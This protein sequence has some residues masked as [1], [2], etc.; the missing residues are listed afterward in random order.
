M[1]VAIA[2]IVLVALLYGSKYIFAS[3]SGSRASGSNSRRAQ[4]LRSG[5]RRFHWALISAYKGNADPTQLD[6]ATAANILADWSCNSIDD[7]RGLM[8]KYVAGEINAALDA[9][10]VIWLAELAAA[11][12]WMT[13]EEVANWSG[14]A[15]QHALASYPSWPA[16]EAAVSEGR[17][18]WWAEIARAPMPASEQTRA[19]AIL[20]ESR[21]VFAEVPWAA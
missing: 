17:Y 4:E 20:T 19:A 7:V 2:T 11:A 16:Y 15:C 5:P 18:R 1:L 21:A 6:A 3:K 9:V 13:I 14:P 10:R 8:S 12:R